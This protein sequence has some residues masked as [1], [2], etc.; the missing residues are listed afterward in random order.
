MTNYLEPQQKPETKSFPISK[1][2]L[3]NQN[4]DLSGLQSPPRSRTIAGHQENISQTNGERNN[5]TLGRSILSALEVQIE[6]LEEIRD[7]LVAKK[8]KASSNPSEYTEDFEEFWK[9]YPKKK[10]KPQ[11]F[12]AWKG[13]KDIEVKK[14]MILLSIGLHLQ[15]VDWNKDS[16]QFIPYPQ[17]WLNEHRWLDSVQV[18]TNF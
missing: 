11:A 7:S 13:I 4:T 2:D 18:A 6:L 3:Q 14:N 16:G 5:A 12:K 15:S 1:E 9:V 10:A 8:R 17:K